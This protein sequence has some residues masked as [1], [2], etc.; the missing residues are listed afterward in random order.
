[1]STLVRESTILGIGDYLE[2]SIQGGRNHGRAR[3]QYGTMKL[4]YNAIA[5]DGYI[6]VLGC[7][8]E[9]RVFICIGSFRI[10]VTGSHDVS[11]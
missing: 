9:I 3:A 11:I 4:E 10:V 7:L 6:S 8:Q 5:L 2:I 1:M